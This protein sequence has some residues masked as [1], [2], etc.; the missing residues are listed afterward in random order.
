M[1][2]SGLASQVLNSKREFGINFLFFF[3]S[4]LCVNN[5]LSNFT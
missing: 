1:R 2:H 4:L 3:R 5:A